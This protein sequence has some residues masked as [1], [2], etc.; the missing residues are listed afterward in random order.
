MKLG[1]ISG[2]FDTTTVDGWDGTTW[3]K[4]IAALNLVVYD[5][6]ISDRSF[7][8]VER[9]ASCGVEIPEKYICFRLGDKVY[10]VE[11]A[12]LDTR[13]NEPYSW[14]YTLRWARKTG[15][16]LRMVDGVP[17][18]SG[19]VEQTQE[20]AHAGIYLDID[21]YNFLSSQQVESL[22]HPVYSIWMPLGTDL[23]TTDEIL[24]EGDYYT[25]RE[26]SRDMSLEFARI[27]KRGDS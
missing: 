18:A 6:F 4:G 16:V 20:V 27:V 5:R 21:Q 26:R 1:Q 9:T 24:I 15:D 14:I 11:S 8:Q 17:R 19:V 7:G 2:Y 12:N 22:R 25:V 23:L 3:T 10:M 13:D